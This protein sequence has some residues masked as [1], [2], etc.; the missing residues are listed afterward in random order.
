MLSRASIYTKSIVP[1]KSKNA[2]S[3]RLDQVESIFK[4]KRQFLNI[5]KKLEASVKVV[6]R[7]TLHERTKYFP[8]FID[9]RTN[10]PK[11]VKTEAQLEIQRILEFPKL[12]YSK[13][14]MEPLIGSIF[15]LY[16]FSHG[17]A[18]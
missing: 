13:L 16:T 2:R 7:S 11:T 18:V 10:E 12:D 9:F 15:E 5:V 1:K 6:E 14:A 4:T 17:R 8:Y 3:A